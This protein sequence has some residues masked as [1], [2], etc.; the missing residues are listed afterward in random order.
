M[1]LRQILFLFL[2]LSSFIFGVDS[3]QEEEEPMI[4]QSG[5]AEYDGK[6]IVLKGDVVIQHELGIIS[7]HQLAV[8][9][10]SEKDKN[11]RFS[12]LK[13][14]EDIVIDSKESGQLYCQEAEID[15]ACLKGVFLGNQKQLEVVYT[16][17]K[18][19]K[20]LEKPLLI[21][22]SGQMQVELTRQYDSEKQSH[23]ASIH[24]IQADHHVTAHYNQEYLILA[25]RALYQRLPSSSP[26]TSTEILSLY[27]DHRPCRV[28]NENGDQLQADTVT[29][30]LTTR[31][32]MLYHV[33][34]TLYANR[35]KKKQ[36]PLHF[37]SENL[38]WNDIDQVLLLQKQVRLQQEEWG[39]LETDKEI[40]IYQSLMDGKR[41]TSMIVAPEET[42][43]TCLDEKNRLLHKMT[44]HGPLIVDH[45][46][47][48]IF[49]Q[50]PFDEQGQVLADK[51][52]YFEDVA[53]DIYAD[54]VW[55]NYENLNGR[56]L[57]TVLL[58][59][60]GHVRLFNRFDGHLQESSS[61]LQ[62]AL[63]DQVD[64]LSGKKEMVLSGQG[65]N[66]VLLFDKGNHMQMS[67]SSLRIHRDEKSHK[68]SIQ[69]IGDVRFTFIEHE[70]N[71][72]KQRL[73][74]EE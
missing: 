69:G 27:S 25:D 33:Q 73:H 52:V 10:S 43:L 54:Q 44:C 8:I 18:K 5:E 37:S 68:E 22:K 12:F 65:G 70:F 38:I 19:S 55:L 13:M 64:Y 17:G 48:Q 32:L 6:E 40:Q 62:Y 72:L 60:Q 14:K 28:I 2:G 49:M 34:G 21:L 67:A 31:R 7:A 66:R 36:L 61:V 1:K 74:L 15:Y 26:N 59:M 4:I 51:Q 30:D 24:Q 23:F 42:K 58:S 63:A 29:V 45:K 35:D 46:N 11:K 50:S 53:G 57:A 39:Y 41:E 71:Q 9:P 56:S 47:S 16:S 20:N 3:I